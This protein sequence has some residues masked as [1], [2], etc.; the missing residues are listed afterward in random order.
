MPKYIDDL[1]PDTWE[2]DADPVPRGIPS[3]SILDP[4]SEKVRT[5]WIHG[6]RKLESQ[7]IG[8]PSKYVPP[9]LL[10]GGA[11]STG[12][13]YKPVWPEIVRKA[14][15]DGHDPV[16]LVH[17]Y[18]ERHVSNFDPA[19]HPNNIFRAE[20]LE[21][22]HKARRQELNRIRILMVTHE[23]TWRT[24]V[25]AA[26]VILPDKVAAHRKA[27]KDVSNGLTPL[28]RYCVARLY[29]IDDLAEAWKQLA[30][31]QFNGYPE[32]YLQ[33]WFNIL[34]KEFIPKAP[35]RAS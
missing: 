32:A 18:F 12:K 11:T 29:E 23:A 35:N 17:T 31:Q 16:D 13:K 20:N 6:V 33:Y 15:R 7:R 8:A 34:P 5:A 2:M 26:M 21:S 1:P 9:V 10:D 28:F 19:E 24:A 4:E 3:R 30:H 25:W 22:V 14:N 27:L